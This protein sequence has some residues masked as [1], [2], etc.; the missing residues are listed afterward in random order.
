MRRAAALARIGYGNTYPNPAVGC[1]IVRPDANGDD[2]DVV[3]GFG[4]HPRAGWPHAE[5]FALLEACGHVDDGVTAARS[6]MRSSPPSDDD[7]HD[8]ASTAGGGI[9][10]SRLLLDAYASTTNGPAALFGGR[11]DGA[12]ASIS[13][14]ST[15]KNRICVSGDLYLRANKSSTRRVLFARK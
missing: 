8:G 6:V 7:H 12:N 3:V 4:F 15:L 2:D 14:T 10:A 11:L 13:S 1:V 9:A 5:V